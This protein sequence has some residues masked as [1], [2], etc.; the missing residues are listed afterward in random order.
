MCPKGVYHVYKRRCKEFEK[1]D[2]VHF[3]VDTNLL[4]SSKK[5]FTFNQK[6]IINHKMSL[7]SKYQD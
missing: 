3:L 6:T 5:S 7:L 2:T 1:R 4:N